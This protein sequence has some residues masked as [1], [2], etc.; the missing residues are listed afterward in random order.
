ME[1]V[2]TSLPGVM[3]VRINAFSDA[4]GAFFKYFG[5]P[6]LDDLLGA[7]SIRQINHSITNKVGTVRGMHFQFPPFSEMK[8]IVCIHGCV[9]DVAVDLRKNSPTFGQYCP[10]ELTP[11]TMYVVPE[12]CAHGF[13]ALKPNS[14]LLYLHTAAYSPK[15]EGGINCLDDSLAIEWPLPPIGLS[16]RDQNLPSLSGFPGLDVF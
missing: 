3:R 7:R 2:E 13:Q 16:E 12:G 1:I 4:R 5:A 10:T 9:F 15:H 14:E 6:E 8:L 11:G